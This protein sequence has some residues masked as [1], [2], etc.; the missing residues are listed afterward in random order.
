L[1]RGYTSN[2]RAD[3]VTAF[4]LKTL[5]TIQETHVAGQNPDAIVYDRLGGHVFTFNGRSKDASVLDAMTLATVT[6]I[7]LPDK[8]EF[9]VDDDDGTIF[10]NIDSEQGQLVAIDARTLTVKATWPLPGCASPSGLALDKGHH[11]LFSVCDGKVM[12]V[13]DA[14]S[15]RQ[16]A[17]V[18]IGEGPD[19]A[20]Y[21]NARGLAFSSNGEG[22]LSIVRSDGSDRYEVLRTVPT[23]RGARTM[24]LDPAAGRVY[25]VTADFDPAPPATAAQPHP[26]PVP[27]PGSFTVLVVAYQ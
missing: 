6:T 15:G 14:L 22:T 8:P 11:R 27:K 17:K 10:V 19:A 16:I 24:A 5:R 25:L 2:G 9:A 7:P 13:T 1:N 26:R 3:S 18:A 21:D 20:A 23:Q 12:A 4:D